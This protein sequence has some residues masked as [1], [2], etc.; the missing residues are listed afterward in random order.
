MYDGALTTFPGT[1]LGSAVTFE[2]VDGQAEVQ[3]GLDSIETTD[4]EVARV[5][6]LVLEHA[7]TRPT[8]S[9]GVIAL[10]IKHAERLDDAV[11]EA[12]RSAPD[13]APFFEADTD[14]RFF[15]KNLER[16]QGDERDAIIVS[17]GYGKTPHGRV[18]HRFGPAQHR[19]R[20]AP[21]QR[22]DHPGSGADDRRVVAA[23]DR[24][25]SLTGSRPGAPSCCATSSPTPSRAARRLPT[26]ATDRPRPGLPPHT[27]AD[28]LRADLARRLRREGHT[29]HE[30]FGSAAQRVDLAVEDPHHRGR[31]LIAIETDGPRYAALSSTRDR[32]RLRPEQLERLGWTHVRVWSTDLFR[33]P[34]REI[35]RILGILRRAT[36][37]TVGDRAET[38]SSSTAG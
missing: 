17:V 14:E 22:R 21:P 10:G 23:V 38:A 5:V 6:A 11:T 13:A 27:T 3:P 8:E 31:A 19:G 7:R 28:P 12:L 33:D 34:A 2:A 36:S 18:L 26:G 35:S 29:V 16:V 30:E 9:L 37:T 20:R 32:D 4:A 15:V 25:R 1:S 24:P